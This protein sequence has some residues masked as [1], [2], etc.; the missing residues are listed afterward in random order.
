VPV[1]PGHLDGGCID[2]LGYVFFCRGPLLAV[3]SVIVAPRR[4]EAEALEPR[5]AAEDGV[6]VFAEGAAAGN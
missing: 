4:H 2:Q 1:T 6:P 3:F 5:H